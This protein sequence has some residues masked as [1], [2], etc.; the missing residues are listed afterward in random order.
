MAAPNLKKF[1]NRKK[2]KELS[3]VGEECENIDLVTAI[4]FAMAAQL[5]IL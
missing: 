3:R 4:G 2:K 5:S 1:S